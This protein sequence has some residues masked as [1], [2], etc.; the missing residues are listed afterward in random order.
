MSIGSAL[1]AFSFS[2][3]SCGGNNGHA[4]SA[5]ATPPSSPTFAREKNVLA[6]VTFALML[7]RNPEDETKG[8]L[9]IVIEV[10]WFQV[11]DLWCCKKCRN[12]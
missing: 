7:Q 8:T 4:S 6:S 11:F 3:A 1:S 5:Y 12:V 10:S 9:T 2:K